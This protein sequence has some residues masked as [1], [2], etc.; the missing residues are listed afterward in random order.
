MPEK[1][2]C[3]PFCGPDCC[4]PH[5]ILI[6]RLVNIRENEKRSIEKF[7]ST[8]L[9]FRDIIPQDEPIPDNL[10]EYEHPLLHWASVLGKVSAVEYL[11]KEGYEPT[12]KSPDKGQTALHRV[13]VCFNIVYSKRKISEQFNKL[14]SLVD[15]LAP[16]LFVKDDNGDTPLHICAICIAEYQSLSYRIPLEV[17]LEKIVELEDRGL[18]KTDGINLRN[19]EGK[20]VLHILA[21]RRQDQNCADEYR[22]LIKKLLDFGADPEIRDHSGKSAMDIAELMDNDI[23]ITEMGKSRV[24]KR[25]RGPVSEGSFTTQKRIC[26]EQSHKNLKPVGDQNVVSSTTQFWASIKKPDVK[27][28][29][30]NV[31]NLDSNDRLSDEAS[32]STVVGPLAESNNRQ[33]LSTHQTGATPNE[34]NQPK[35]KPTL[36]TLL[37]RVDEKDGIIIEAV[38]KK[39][40]VLESDCLKSDERMTDLSQKR[41]SCQKRRD[42]ITMEIKTKLEELK[43]LQNEQAACEQDLEE[44]E[45]RIIEENEARKKIAENLSDCEAIVRS[46][47]GV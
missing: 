6:V 24:K 30:V 41:Q 25:K 34:S 44:I 17:M 4:L 43:T 18:S 38:E 9:K 40:K 36:E 27:P 39:R 20:T 19:R 21:A 8:Y 42:G 1:K 5:H 32:S 33:P 45:K 47:R 10:R 29:L 11:I 13:A 26:Q 28:S 12:V 3:P 37:K 23:M 2:K 7:K 14:R 22:V 16:A 15:L 31:S 46:L 35:E